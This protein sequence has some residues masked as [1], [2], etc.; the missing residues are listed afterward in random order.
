MFSGVFKILIMRYIRFEKDYIFN[1]SLK[2]NKLTSID[3]FS[4][5]LSEFKD[6]KIVRIKYTKDS[7]VRISMKIKF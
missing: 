6:I 1:S 4:E 7:I 5:H 2:L 3:G